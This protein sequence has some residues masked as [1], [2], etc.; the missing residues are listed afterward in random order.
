MCIFFHIILTYYFR[1][2]VLNWGFYLDMKSEADK[3]YGKLNFS[4]YDKIYGNLNFSFYDK[5]YGK[6]NFLSMIKSMVTLIFLS[7]KKSII[8]LIFLSI[9]AFFLYIVFLILSFIKLVLKKYFPCSRK[10]LV[11]LTDQN[12]KFDK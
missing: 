3:I 11:Y 7:M 9:Y 12:I 1:A 4:F 2:V 8:N 10:G 5:I 6:L